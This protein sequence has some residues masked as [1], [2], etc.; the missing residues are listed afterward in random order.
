MKAA[1]FLVLAALALPLS[2][3]DKETKVPDASVSQVRWG[4]VV[5]EVEFDA[6]SL[7][8]KVVVVEEWGVNCPPCIASLPDMARLAKRYDSKGLA[9]IGFEV[10]GGDKETINKLLKKA[11]VKYPVMTGGMVP[12]STGGIPHALVFD[13]TG[14]LVWHG[15]PANDDFEDAVK[16]ALRAMPKL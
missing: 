7:E 6:S 4:Q 8:G 5:N 1:A 14:K 10:Q 13:H 2:A 3:K 9:V 11:R 16:D 15:H 12:V